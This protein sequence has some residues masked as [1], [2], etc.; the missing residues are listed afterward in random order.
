LRRNKVNQSLID[1]IKLAYKVH[2][3]RPIRGFFFIKR[4]N[5][6]FS[7]PLVALAIHRGVV[8]RLAPGFEF[9]GG[10][11]DAGAIVAVEWAARTFGKAWVQ[12]FLD[13]FDGQPERDNEA[14]YQE[15]YTLG[16]ALGLE[17]LPI[18]VAGP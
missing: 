5:A 14:K 1:E 12:G 13:G 15:G 7:C 3:L 16:V 2:R 18:P 10:A 8:H 6:D 17:I 9:V 4:E 11:V